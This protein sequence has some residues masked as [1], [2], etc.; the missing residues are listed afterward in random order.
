MDKDYKGLFKCLGLIFLSV[1]LTCKLPRDS[2]SI[3]QYI[4][5]P[6]RFENSVLYLSGLI[7]LAMLFLG[8]RGLFKLKWFAEKSKLLIFILVIALVVPMMRSSLDFVKA[9]YFRMMDNGLTAI[10]FKDTNITFLE[11][12]DNEATINV[13]LAL[14]DYGR[15]VRDFKVRMYLPESLENYF[16]AD[17]LEFEELY[18]TYGDQHDLNI[19]KKITVQLAEGTTVDDI[20]DTNWDWETFRYELYNDSSF[21]ELIYHGV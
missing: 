7:P 16:K 8:I 11:I 6:I 18:K 17:F 15:D 19:D 14:T 20:W 2:Y 5:L 21:T 3:I 13:R 10:D 9:S 4:V 12:K 1:L